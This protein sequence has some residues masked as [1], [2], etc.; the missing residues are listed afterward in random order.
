MVLR[1]RSVSERRGAR[2][3]SRTVGLWDGLL[4]WGIVLFFYFV[5]LYSFNR[6]RSPLLVCPSHCLSPLSDSEWGIIKNLL[7]SLLFS[8]VNVN[9]SNFFLR[10]RQSHSLVGYHDNRLPATVPRFNNHFI[11]CYFLFL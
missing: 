6:L 11:I 1:L 8:F 5:F 10:T 7:L 9:A 4:D 3:M 2:L